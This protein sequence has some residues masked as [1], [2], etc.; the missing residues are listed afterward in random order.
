MQGVVQNLL[1]EVPNAPLGFGPADV[2]RQ[3]L[4]LG[5]GQLRA[6]P[7]GAHLRAVAVGEGPLGAGGEPRR[8]ALAGEVEVA[9]LLFQRAALPGAHERV[10]A[11]GHHRNGHRSS[12]HAPRASKMAFW[13]WSRFSAWSRTAEAGESITSSVTSWPRRAGRQCM[14]SA[15]GAAF[16]IS[17]RFT[18]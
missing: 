15:P 14:K 13:M 10:P 8:D 1:E 11:D 6:Q 7:G 16:S 17:A 12:S 18:W 3:R 9:P 5:G 2:E 4:D